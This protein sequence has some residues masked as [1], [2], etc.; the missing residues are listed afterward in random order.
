MF[1]LSQRLRPPCTTIVERSKCLVIKQK[2][3]MERQKEQSS[4]FELFDKRND[5]T[6]KAD[7]KSG[8]KGLK[9]L[10][11]AT[12]AAGI[13]ILSPLTAI[14]LAA[15]F[16]ASMISGSK[17]KDKKGIRHISKS[18]KTQ[19]ELF[20]PNDILLLYPEMIEDME[21]LQSEDLEEQLLGMCNIRE[22]G[23]T[24]FYTPMIAELEFRKGQGEDAVHM[25]EEDIEALKGN[26]GATILTYYK[27]LFHVKLGQSYE[28]PEQSNNRWRHFAE[29]R[30]ACRYVTKHATH[31][32]MNHHRERILDKAREDFRRIEQDFVQH[33]LEIPY[34]QRKLIV[35]VES[36]P[37]LYQN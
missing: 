5:V 37:D 25:F 2:E 12:V 7:H 10:A 22:K 8:N 36:Y 13:A 26:E 18:S 3:D 23:E 15:A 29:A 35:L 33:F 17:K 9:P 11:T 30:K 19:Q 28:K 32:T 34:N 20:N 16:G 31:K 6:K 27:Y 14:G 21:K 1:E 24:A 4:Y